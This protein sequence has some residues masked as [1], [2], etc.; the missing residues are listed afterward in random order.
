LES[1]K[2]ELRSMPQ[3]SKK[4]D[5]CIGGLYHI[6]SN[7]DLLEDVASHLQPNQ[8]LLEDVVSHL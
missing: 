2:G 7:Q 1:E 3:L 8:D 5:V 4:W 6:V